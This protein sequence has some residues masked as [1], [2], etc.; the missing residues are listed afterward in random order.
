MKKNTEST[1]KIIASILNRRSK[2]KLIFSF[3]LISISTFLE[4]LSLYFLQIAINLILGNDNTLNKL[5]N[6][7]FVNPSTSN[8]VFIFIIFLIISTLINSYTIFNIGRTVAYIGTDW[9]QRSF[10]KIFEKDLIYGHNKRADSIV[11]LLINDIGF[12]TASLSVL[13][14]ALGIG[15]IGIGISI[16]LLISETLIFLLIIFSICFTYL[17]F[18]YIT[19]SRLANISKLVVTSKRRAIDQ[20]FQSIKYLPYTKLEEKLEYER[21][22]FEKYSSILYKNSQDSKFYL[23]TPKKSAEFIGLLIVLASVIYLTQNSNFESDVIVRVGIV[24]IGLNRVLPGINNL[25][26]AWGTL[27]TYQSSY[28]NIFELLILN[29]SD[30]MVNKKRKS[31]YKNFK[32]FKKS[33]EEYETNNK[34][35][36]FE[37]VSLLSKNKETSIFNNLNMKIPLNKKIVITGK[38]GIGK[39]TLLLLV[40]GLYVPNKGHIKIYGMSSKKDKFIIPNSD[41]WQKN[42]SL[43]LQD[44]YYDHG[45]IL[46]LFNSKNQDETEIFKINECLKKVNLYNKISSFQNNLKTN[47]GDPNLKLSGGQL[48]RLTLAR[49]LYLNRSIILLDEATSALDSENKSLFIDNLLFNSEEKS[50]WFVTHDKEIIKKFDYQLLINKEGISLQKMKT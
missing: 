5:N 3:I 10:R 12:A 25:Y 41:V 45:L 8:I 7:F 44:T 21:K 40:S 48:Q 49:L 50:I 34:Y 23:N 43:V 37:D 17:A 42:L 38:S 9:S 19:K 15:I 1:Y 4:V 11:N 32:S 31:K 16:Y 39:S 26:T 18:V 33:G 6:I 36:V 35:I 29:N 27:K 20:I 22:I 47:L 46:D 28:L 24:I 14:N 30:Y 13:V 2:E